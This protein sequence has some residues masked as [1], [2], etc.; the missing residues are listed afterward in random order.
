M[1]NLYRVSNL[2]VWLQQINKL[3]L[4]LTYL[5]IDKIGEGVWI[6]QSTTLARPTVR[7][8]RS[9]T[10]RRWNVVIKGSTLSHSYQYNHRRRQ[11]GTDSTANAVGTE[12]MMGRGAESGQVRSL[13]RF[14]SSFRYNRLLG[15]YEIAHTT[16]AIQHYFLQRTARQV[17]TL[18]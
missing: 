6:S 13:K 2:A 1:Y 16:T 7:R 12:C 17:T 4:L 8:H 11:G 5:T 3:Y 14:I 15:Q 10:A 9:S 18:L